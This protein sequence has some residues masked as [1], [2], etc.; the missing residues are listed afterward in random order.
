MYIDKEID[1]YN[2]NNKYSIYIAKIHVY[3]NDKFRY[4]I[5]IGFNNI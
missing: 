4:V 5:N 3:N 2:N 1:R